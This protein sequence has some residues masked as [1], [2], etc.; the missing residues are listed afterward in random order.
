MPWRIF[1]RRVRHQ[2]VAVCPI[3]GEL[4]VTV[5]RSDN[6]AGIE[7]AAVALAGGP[8]NAGP[9]TNRFGS[10]HRQPCAPGTYVVSVGLADRNALLYEQP[11]PVTNVVVP[12]GGQGFCD[13][14]VD[15]WATLAVEVLKRHDNTPIAQVPVVVTGPSNRTGARP[16]PSAARNAPTAHNGKVHFPQLT[17]GSYAVDVTTGT[18]YVPIAQQ[19]VQLAVGQQ[20]VLRILLD[21]KP[22]LRIKVLREGDNQP[23]ANVKVNALR[24]G[25]AAALS[26]TTDTDGI[27]LFQHV[28]SGDYTVEPELDGETRKLY[29]W[30]VPKPAPA[31]T[32]LPL[33][34]EVSEVTLHLKPRKLELVSTDDH[35]AP[36]AESLDVKYHIANLS[37]RTVTL[38]IHGTDY[39]NNPIYR[40]ELDDGERTD[41]DDR[42]ISWDGKANCSAGPL[43]G[44]KYIHP[45]Y[46]PYTVK[47]SSKLGHDGV[48][49]ASFKVL[50]HSV[51]LEL[52]TWVAGAA[53][54]QA[55]DPV[56]WVKHRLNDLGYFAGP[57]N[58]AVNDQLRR[59]VR[60]YTRAHTGLYGGVKEI[61]DHTNATFQTQLANGEGARN[62]LAG[63]SLPG[64]GNT[65]RAYIDHDFFYGGIGA[66]DE[67]VQADGH[68]AKDRRYLD[69]W[70][71][72]IE[73]RVLLVS[74]A[75]DGTSARAGVDAPEAVG[76]IDIRF[77]AE[78]PAEDTSGLP[79]NKPRDANVPSPVRE[80]VDKALKATRGGDPDDD[81][82]PAA[83]NGA[84]GGRIYFRIGTVH[85]PWRLTS[86][87]D[88]GFVPCCVDPAHA[89]KVGRAGALFRGSYIAGDDYVL[90][91]SISFTHGSTDLG[92]KQALLGLHRE[93]QQR[94]PANAGR[95]VEDVLSVKT[96]KIELWRRH[97]IAAVVQWPASGR[98]IT[99]A[100][101]QS[102]YAQA[103]CD[104]Q[105]GGTVQVPMATLFPA[106]SA[107]EGTLLAEI[108]AAADPTNASAA[109]TLRNEYFA[110]PLPTQGAAESDDDWAQR[111]WDL[112]GW[113]SEL[114]LPVGPL[115]E[116]IGQLIAQRVQELNG[117]GAIV[118]EQDWC[119]SLTGLNGGVYNRPGLYCKGEPDGVVL[120]NNQ[121]TATEQH[122]FL[123][124]HELAH[125][126][127][128]WH[129]ETSRSGWLKRLFRLANYDNRDHHD[130]NDHNCMM[131]YPD[132]I[133]SRPGLSWNI[134][135]AAEPRFCGKCTLKLRGWKIVAGLPKES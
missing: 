28:D 122:G 109:P 97:H 100:D 99:W 62:L 83:Q 23:C 3:P 20:H 98:A 16:R 107:H 13:V 9:V 55:A 64:V 123:Y 8:E 1:S 88:D 34:D 31:A 25:A 85:E 66:T 102:R 120:M 10:S 72:P 111:V 132:G 73:A 96:G 45:K 22:T 68:S 76:D 51:Q 14:D 103:A 21:C 75:D 33:R 18:R 50:Y 46:A 125:T 114:E 19:A 127:F 129:H 131:C 134:G 126:R 133:T 29:R 57:V 92:N 130:L 59:A 67:F 70:E 77:H 49:E 110:W 39:P 54:T 60:R 115:D 32:T 90:H 106:G 116:R 4:F 5:S 112:M 104:L 82:C 117:P 47:L 91:A 87:H 118:W 7:G 52:G 43:S 95:G 124:A 41:G 74:K 101:V 61:D 71:V 119:P 44:G 24:S 12:P 26:A 56:K 65:A 105:T 6:G 94:L 78:D 135:D 40:H 58:A 48:R 42:T 2:P 27:C 30:R 86:S 36:R 53:P 108:R 15:P 113:Y 11:E 84:R 89:N 35:F 93:H 80:Y 121:M 17:H 69:G 79:T 128:L 63:G 38:E 81:N 37:G